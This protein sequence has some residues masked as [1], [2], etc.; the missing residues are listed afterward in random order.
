[1]SLFTKVFSARK[2][3]QGFTLLELMVVV[4]IVGVLASLG[5]P[6]YSKM[7]KKAKVA[8]ADAVLG[9]MRGAQ[10]RY[11]AE[12]GAYTFTETNLDIDIPGYGGYPASSYF[13]YYSTTSGL[14]QA[15]GKGTVSGVTVNLTITGTRTVSGL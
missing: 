11:Y 15:V 1:M 13:T 14:V 12:Y 8:E 5:L 9:A 7:M 10:L 4:L 3:N 2:I 6:G